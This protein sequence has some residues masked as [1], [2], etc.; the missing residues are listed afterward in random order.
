MSATVVDTNVILVA[1][2]KHAD[3]TDDCILSCVLALQKL[4][5]SG[6]LVI[7]DDHLILKE[8]QNKTSPRKGKGVG[9][10]F[11]KWL[12]QNAANRRHCHQVSLTERA[13]NDYAEFPVPA[14]MSK[15][16][17][18][19]RKFAAV[20]N[21]HPDKPPILQAADCKWLDWHEQL[22]AVGIAVQFICPTDA[23]RFYRKKFPKKAMP[24]LP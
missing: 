5:R 9:D 10:V 14:L 15:F 2:G 7:D 13:E 8:Y 20:A 21:C 1:N 23:Q 11:L 6:T 12:L 19:D 22:Q 4:M 16:D 17:A 18:P 3:V 24:L